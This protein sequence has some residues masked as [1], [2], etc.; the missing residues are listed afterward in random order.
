MLQA[1]TEA[2]KNSIDNIIEKM[3]DLRQGL[4]FTRSEVEELKLKCADVVPSV[5]AIPSN[6]TTTLDLEHDIAGL[7]NKIDDLENRSHRNNLF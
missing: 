7:Q 3:R 5:N 1:H 6:R 4:E 2:T